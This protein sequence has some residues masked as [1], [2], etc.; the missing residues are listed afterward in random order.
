MIVTVTPPFIPNPTLN[1][2]HHLHPASWATFQSSSSLTKH[3]TESMHRRPLT[4]AARSSSSRAKP[5]PAAAAPRGAVQTGFPSLAAGS[6][7]RCVWNIQ[8]Q[9]ALFFVVSFEDGIPPSRASASPPPLS[10]PVPRPGF[11]A[12]RGTQRV[13][14][15]QR[16]DAS[17]AVT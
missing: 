13:M 3:V 4:C 12:M 16:S 11:W 6:A 1:L 10:R 2:I 5:L 9:E 14:C 15:R 8:R 17:V 7:A